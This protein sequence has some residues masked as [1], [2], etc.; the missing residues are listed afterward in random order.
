MS[1]LVT[2]QTQVRDPVGI[3]LAC[4]R[5]R[6]PEPVRDTF[7]LFGTQA[8]GWGVRLPA[9]IEMEAHERTPPHLISKGG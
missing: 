8:T 3:Q 2:I 7:R 9:P 6:L 1:H 4:A 5:L